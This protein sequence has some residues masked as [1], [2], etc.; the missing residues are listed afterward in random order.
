MVLLSLGSDLFAWWQ[1][2][3]CFGSSVHALDA[4]RPS[5]LAVE[6]VSQSEC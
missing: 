5:S 3:Q 2:R 1:E 4:K 6:S